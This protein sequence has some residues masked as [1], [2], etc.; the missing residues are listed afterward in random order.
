[1][2]PVPLTFSLLVTVAV[3][4]EQRVLRYF[5]RK[6]TS[7]GRLELERVLPRFVACLLVSADVSA[8]H[9]C[10]TIILWR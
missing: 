8:S 9:G 1:M 5:S 2:A 3:W 4:Q 10:D 6:A 7:S